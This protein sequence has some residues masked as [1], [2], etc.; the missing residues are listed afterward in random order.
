[1]FEIAGKISTRQIVNAERT[2]TFARDS[3]KFEIARVQDSGTLLY[4][5]IECL[6]VVLLFVFAQNGLFIFM[7]N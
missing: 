4:M 3:A 1:M 5:Y 7:V 6:K 2:K